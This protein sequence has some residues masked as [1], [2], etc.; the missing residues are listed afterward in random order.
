MVGFLIIFMLIDLAQA[1]YI[2]HLKKEISARD[3]ISTDGKP[4]VKKENKLFK[5]LKEIFWI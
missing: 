5:L 3:N 1:L 4:V 2:R